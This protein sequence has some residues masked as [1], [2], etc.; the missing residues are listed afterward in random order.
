MLVEL[1][2]TSCNLISR[3]KKKNLVQNLHDIN[4]NLTSENGL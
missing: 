3:G 2:D 4:Q 1:L